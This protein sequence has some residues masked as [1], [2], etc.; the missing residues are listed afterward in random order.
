MDDWTRFLSHT[1]ADEEAE[2][3]AALREHGKDTNTTN[4]RARAVEAAG[5]TLTLPLRNETRAELT[6]ADPDEGREIIE[7]GQGQ[8]GDNGQVV[9]KSRITR[10][11]IRY[12]KTVT[13][14]KED[15]ADCRE[16]N[17]GDKRRRD[18]EGRSGEVI[19]RGKKA[20]TDKE[21]SEEL[22]QGI[23]EK[24]QNNIEFMEDY[25][26]GRRSTMPGGDPE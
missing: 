7:G 12:G 14:C 4:V 24:A 1:L 9:I 16:T 6:K 5:M 3:D 15:E 13:E 25:F 21:R 19:G 2:R 26:Q 20:Q 18:N 10:R 8:V 11:G 23:K 22:F 17:P